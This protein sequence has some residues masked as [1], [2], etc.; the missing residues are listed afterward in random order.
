VKKGLLFLLFIPFLILSCEIDYSLGMGEGSEENYPDIV[1]RGVTQ[2]DIQGSQV[3]FVEADVA[4]V[5]NE[6]GETR[7]EKVTF[8]ELNQEHEEIRRGNAGEIHQYENEDLLMKGQISVYDHAEDS[9]VEAEEL[10]WDEG[11]KTLKSPDDMDVRISLGEDGSLAGKGFNADLKTREI[12]IL[13]D[14]TGT[15]SDKESE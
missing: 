9:S 13:S 1:M 14:V 11:E 15:M 6:T 12:R 2:V 4:E 5:Y 7:F 8:K 10:F 3:I